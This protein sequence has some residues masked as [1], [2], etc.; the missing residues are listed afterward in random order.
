MKT[1]TKK[2]Q[3]KKTASP[4]K[5]REKQFEPHYLALVLVAF[6]LLEGFTLTSTTAPDWGQGTEV[7]DMSQAVHQTIDDSA[8]LFQPIVNTISDINKFYE[9]SATELIPLLDLSDYDV[10][11]DVAL[12]TDGV[13]AF[14]DEAS[15]ELAN[16]FDFSSTVNPWTSAVAGAS[17]A[18]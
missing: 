7:L 8:K 16:L 10:T 18:Y 2:K 4:R 17:I 3:T 11:E 5:K 12:I 13:A 15:I 1:K 6:L 9:L 14:Y